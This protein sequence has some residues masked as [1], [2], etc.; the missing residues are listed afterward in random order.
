M[1]NL[2]DVAVVVY[3]YVVGFCCGVSVTA[4]C[5]IRWFRAG[6]AYAD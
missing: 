5:C 1:I 6:R 2:A 3:G 4:G